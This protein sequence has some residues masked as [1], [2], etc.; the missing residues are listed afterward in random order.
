[1][2]N[3]HNAQGAVSGSGS[4]RTGQMSC[5]SKANLVAPAHPDP[6][7]PGFEFLRSLIEAQVVQRLEAI[8]EKVRQLEQ[9][10]SGPLRARAIRL[11]EVLNMLAISK[12]TLYAR[13]NPTSASY[14]PEMPKPFKV[15]S[16][17]NDRAPSAWW[18]G[19]ILEYLETCARARLAS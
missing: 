19:E 11:R 4:R 13:L 1:M 3:L 18:D 15:G 9:V 6:L 8:F 12:S 16:P 7:E 14:D 17:K 10:H 2:S 5:R